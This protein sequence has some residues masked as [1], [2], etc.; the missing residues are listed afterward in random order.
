MKAY[1]TARRE[2]DGSFTF[3]IRPSSFSGEVVI[4]EMEY[5]YRT[6]DDVLVKGRRCIGPS[7]ARKRGRLL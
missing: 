4:G 5:R 1:S 2:A 3:S 6:S 7:R